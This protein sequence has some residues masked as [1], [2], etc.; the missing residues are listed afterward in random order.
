[1]KSI[2]PS[3]PSLLAALVFLLAA[4][5]A[6]AD[7]ANDEYLIV[8]GGP[9][10]RKWEDLRPP[11][12]QHDR[13]WGN[14]VRTARIRMEQLRALPNG[15]RINITWMVYR[16]GYVGRS[17]EEGRS[18]TELIHSVRDKFRIKLV[19][20]HSGDDVIDY[21][22]HGMNRRVHKLSGFEFYGH[23]NRSCFMFD[24]SCDIIG[25]SSA[26]L[27]E[28][29]LS[30]IRGGLFAPNAHVQSYGCHTGES[31]SAHWKR[32]TGTTMIGAI[33]K[34]DYSYSYQN[35]LPVINQGHWAR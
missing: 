20:F 4:A 24:Y 1:M 10:L 13:W 31:M 28:N 11:H 14:F 22:N 26:Y 32:A 34:T 25:V 27:H 15:E 7:L 21:L 33:G 19:W 17:A 9:A 3:L 8:S 2:L 35:T 12:H 5:P 30:K 29:D 23:S 6:S 18:L 16:P